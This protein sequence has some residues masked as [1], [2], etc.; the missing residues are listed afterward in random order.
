[1]LEMFVFETN[2]LIEQLEEILLDFEQNKT[3]SNE[4][5]NEI[6]RIMHTIKGSSAMMMFDIISSLAHIVEDLFYFIRESQPLSLDYSLICDLVLASA[7]FIKLEISKIEDG[8]DSDGNEKDITDKIKSYLSELSGAYKEQGD[9]ATITEKIENDKQAYYISTYDNH[10]E[11]K[12]KKFS[13]RVF[14][15]DGCQMEN[16]RAYTIIHNLKDFCKEIYHVPEN[17]VEDN[18]SAD[19]IIENGFDVYFSSASDIDEFKKIFEQA[20]FVKTYEL[21]VVDNFENEAA[22]HLGQD[23]Y[24]GAP[25]S[26]TGEEIS[27][28]Q[29]DS[30]Q[31]AFK[32]IKQS[33][34]SVNITKLDKLMD[35]VGEIVIT[36]SMVTRNPDLNGLQLDNFCKAA[37][38]LRKLTDELQ[39]TVM[40]IRM[41]PVGATF[42][43]MHRIVR[44]MGKKLIKEVELCIRG[45]DTE[46]DK[47]IID[48][49]SDP[50]MHIIR[51]AVDHGLEPEEERIKKGKDSRGRITLEAENVGGEVV[52]TVTDN[53][54]GLDKTKILEK[55]REKGLAIKADREYTDREIFSFILL[56]GFSTKENVTEFSGR[57]VGMDV[58]KKNIEQ[59]GGSVLIDSKIG[60]GT[61]ITIKIPLTLAIVDGM[62]VSVGKSIYTIPITS[63][64]ESFRP[65]EKDIIIDAEGSEMIMIRGSCYPVL[66]NHRLFNVETEIQDLCDGIIVLIEANER[67]VCLFVDRLIGEQQVVVKPLPSYLM[68]YEAKESGIG[69]CTILGDGSISLILDVAGIVARII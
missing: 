4:S 26:I 14:F 7:D 53:G 18:S 56:P 10:D 38:Q 12:L 42:Q 31:R 40:S 54:R 25:A 49:L 32:N 58:V 51:N 62:E 8:K 11:I 50:L 68:K 47:N 19:Y 39:D 2:Q 43:K 20:L 64:R 60:L 5:I 46:V 67:A 59:V 57:G 45:E 61:K 55:A 52:I 16:I 41:V 69:G 33:L 30:T 48:H 37:R 23:L 22:E 15:E 24:I 21:S 28:E 66:R 17:I 6:F 44:D 13:A 36:E 1:M 63:I 29:Q 3:I 35:L 34:I 27:P 9:T 65:N